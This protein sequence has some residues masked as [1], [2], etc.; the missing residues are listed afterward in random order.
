M[1]RSAGAGAWAESLRS[2]EFHPALAEDV[3]GAY[4]C[5]NAR[6]G[7][8]GERFLES[9]ATRIESLELFPGRFLQVHGSV[10]QATIPRFPYLVLYALKPQSF[11]FYACFHSSQNR[12]GWL[13]CGNF[14]LRECRKWA[15]CSSLLST[16]SPGSRGYLRHHGS[17]EGGADGSWRGGGDSG[18]VPII[19]WH[20]SVLDARHQA[21]LNGEEHFEDW[22]EAKRK[23]SLLC[24][25][26]EL[27]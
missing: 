6:Q 4:D 27:R 13:A 25:S 26:T 16:G 23:M 11:Y 15:Y 12:D 5:Y 21:V 3:Q 20:Q 14:A 17:I 9:L 10:R 18:N 2:V 7:G 24:A 1:G 19:A 22:E 8:L